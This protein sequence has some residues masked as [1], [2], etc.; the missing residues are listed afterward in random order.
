MGRLLA[1]GAVI[2]ATLIAGYY[3][4][5]TWIVNAIG[6][7]KA[8]QAARDLQLMRER[9]GITVPARPAPSQNTN[10]PNPANFDESKVGHYE[11]PDPLLL[12]DGTPVVSTEV[13]WGKRRQEIIDDFE[14]EVFGRV[15]NSAPPVTWRIVSEEN[16]M[17]GTH[18]VHQKMLIGKVD[19]SAFPS[20]TVEMRLLVAT[21][22]DVEATVPVVLK[23]GSMQHQKDEWKV[24]LLARRWGYAILEPGTVQPDHGADLGQGIIGLAGR[25][26]PRNPGDWGVLRAWAWGASRAFDYLETDP[27]VDRRRIGIEGLSR[28]GKAALVAMAMDERFSLALIAS[29]GVGGAKIMRRRFAEQVENVVVR[30]NYFWFCGNFLKYASS[31]T[32]DDL[33][34]DAHEL[35]ALCAPRPVFISAGS[36]DNGDRWADPKGMFLSAVHAEPV[37]SLLGKKGLG[38]TTFPPEGTPLVDGELAFRQHSDGHTVAPNWPV[39]A[40]WASRY[41]TT[42][43][44]ETK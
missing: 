1:L 43:A 24:L 29:S 15:P 6:G 35:V 26:Q 14:R 28:Y 11:L 4:R 40:E 41:W 3:I 36:L 13:W 10:S 32:P 25:G 33:P 27:H 44:A 38:T 21:P 16:I 34:V 42:H 20:V 5:K 37:Y 31:H 9:V 39:W 8:R 17:M 18:R 30:D 2:L 19:N 22:A 7:R 23:L 12:K